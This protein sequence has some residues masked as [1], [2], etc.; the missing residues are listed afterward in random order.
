VDFNNAHADV[1]LPWFG[2]SLFEKALTLDGPSS[3]QYLDAVD[4]CA[5]AGL[6]E[7]S[8][9][10]GEHGL[11]ALLAPAMAPPTPIDLVNGDHGSGGA[12][13]SSA[14]AGAPILTVPVEMAHGLPVAV[15]VWGARG[16]ERSL[17]AIGRAFEQ[18][19][20][21]SVGPL[22]EPTYVEVL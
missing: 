3:P 13:D 9:T 17:Y 19:R 2:Q 14:L 10:L 20:D 21:R 5:A 8:R 7:L 6:A 12:S 11:D 1:E 22:P 16:S 18:A 15:S 4:A